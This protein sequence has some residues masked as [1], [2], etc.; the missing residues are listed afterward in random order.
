MDQPPPRRGLCVSSPSSLSA[1]VLPL[2]FEKF[3]RLLPSGHE[4]PGCDED[5]ESLHAQGQVKAETPGARPWCLP[6]PVLRL[7]PLTSC[8]FQ[9]VRECGC[10]P[11]SYPFLS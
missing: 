11:S 5:L 3:P 9:E 7:C 2:S 4:M 6:L 10:S 8:S 1:H